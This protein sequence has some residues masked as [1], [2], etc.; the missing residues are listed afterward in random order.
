MLTMT[1]SCDAGVCVDLSCDSCD[2]LFDPGVSVP[3]VPAAIWAAA[4]ARGWAIAI[5]AGA[6]RHLCPTCAGTRRE[7]RMAQA[8]PGMS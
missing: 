2:A 5:P 4:A 8:R 3:P 1:T 7:G 6:G